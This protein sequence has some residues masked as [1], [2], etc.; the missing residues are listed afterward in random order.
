M[1][2]CM[3]YA[4]YVCVCGMYG[5]SVCVC[6]YVCMV[7]VCT[8]VCACACGGCY[9]VNDLSTDPHSLTPSTHQMPNAHNHLLNFT[10]L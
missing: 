10:M 1:C 7:C 3:M 6:M 4:V 9:C 2:M 8:F 5:V